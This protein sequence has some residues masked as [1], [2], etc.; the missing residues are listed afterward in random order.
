MAEQHKTMKRAEEKD[1]DILSYSFDIRYWLRYLITPVVRPK[2]ANNMRSD[3]RLV[4]CPMIPI[5]S[6]PWSVA[7]ILFLTRVIALAAMVAVPVIADA[8]AIIP[9]VESSDN[10][11]TLQ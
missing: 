7:M 3:C 5:P 6:V 11:E 10:S 8:F 1:L 4:N 9:M 2:P